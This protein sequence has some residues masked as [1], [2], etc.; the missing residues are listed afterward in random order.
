MMSIQI[1]AG[2]A[3]KP[4]HRVGAAGGDGKKPTF[5]ARSSRAPLL[6]AEATGRPVSA[7]STSGCSSASACRIAHAHIKASSSVSKVAT[8]IPY[9]PIQK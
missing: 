1:V 3:E 6:A 5:R 4:P 7:P 8:V 9:C 2:Q